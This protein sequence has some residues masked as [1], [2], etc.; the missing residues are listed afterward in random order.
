MKD[1]K[2]TERCKTFMKE[3]KAIANMVFLG[4]CMAE[5]LI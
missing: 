4:T 3:R 1:Q 2:I 5:V